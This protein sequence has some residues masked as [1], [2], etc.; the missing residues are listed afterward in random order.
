MKSSNPVLNSF[1][2]LRIHE[3][4][5][6]IIF[7]IV[8]SFR[9]DA[10][11]FYVPVLPSDTSVWWGIAGVAGLLLSL[12]L[13]E[14]GHILA[15]YRYGISPG[16]RILMPFGGISDEKRNFDDGKAL[17]PALSGPMSSIITA[18]LWYC[19]FLIGLHRNWP[20]PLL[21]I[22]DH[23]AAINIIIAGINLIPAS[24]L[25]GAVILKSALFMYTKSHRTV[26]NISRLSGHFLAIILIAGGTVVVYRGSLAFGIW[27]ILTGAI[28]REGIVLSRKQFSLRDNLEGEKV[29]QFMRL[30]PVTVPS[31]L[32]ID[33][34]VTSYLYRYHSGIF[35]VTSSNQILGCIT[36]EKIRNIP[37]SSWSSLTVADATDICDETNSVSSSADVIQAID[38][39]CKNATGRLLVIDSGEL[40]GIITLKDLL[41]FFSQKIDLREEA[42]GKE[43]E[44]LPSVPETSRTRQTGYP[45]SLKKPELQTLRRISADQQ[46]QADL[47]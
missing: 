26:S 1:R 6:I 12:I 28:L 44:K 10:L 17:I 30:N 43:V 38:M 15:E 41:P 45:D 33:Q 27:W 40:A 7:L 9:K 23:L 18:C 16:I 32:P 29:S 34:F 13:H 19:L 35:P 36:S 22:L 47:P 39:M 14:T 31:Q 37:E 4:W 3:S 25:D 8:W 46:V 2:F 21:F 11:P 20:G 24:P 42:A 5:V